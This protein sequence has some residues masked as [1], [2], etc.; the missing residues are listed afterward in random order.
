MFTLETLLYFSLLG[1]FL[2]FMLL[3]F[4]FNDLRVAHSARKLQP[5]KKASDFDTIF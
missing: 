2:S 3:A 5:K 1:T 4:L